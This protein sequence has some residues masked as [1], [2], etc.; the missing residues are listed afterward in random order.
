MVRK[1]WS[2]DKVVQELV[3]IMVERNKEWESEKK[4][5]GFKYALYKKARSFIFSTIAQ[6]AIPDNN[7]QIETTTYDTTGSSRV[8][9]FKIHSKYDESVHEY[10]K[11]SLRGH[12]NLGTLFATKGFA[13]HVLVKIMDPIYDPNNI[14]ALTIYIASYRLS[15]EEFSP[16]LQ[17]E[18]PILR[19]LL[20]YGWKSSCEGNSNHHK[21]V[22]EEINGKE[23]LNEVCDAGRLEFLDRNKSCRIYGRFSISF[24]EQERSDDAIK[25]EERLREMFDNDEKEAVKLVNRYVINKIYNPN[26]DNLL[27]LEDLGIDDGTILVVPILVDEYK[28]PFISTDKYDV[29]PRTYS[30]AVIKLKS[31]KGLKGKVYYAHKPEEESLKEFIKKYSDSISRHT[32]A[33][34]KQVVRVYDK[35]SGKSDAMYLDDFYKYFLNS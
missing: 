15:S 24:S 8:G 3:P 10:L 9:G 23:V 5:I 17:L 2:L 32:L 21:Q 31:I 11:N 7:T 4:N 1:D 14:K 30:F 16:P 35:K 26:R 27:V 12:N 19:D 33:P 34:L 6:I 22:K 20:G 29:Y 18:D 25:L 13:G 28:K